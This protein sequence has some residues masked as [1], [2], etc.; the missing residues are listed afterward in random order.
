MAKAPTNPYR[1]SECGWTTSRWVGRCGECQ[2]WG[3]VAQGA[4]P[5]RRVSSAAPIE[6]ALPISRVPIDAARA[7]PTRIGELDRV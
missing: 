2:A 7:I 3:S 1:C 6:P 5:A 4:A